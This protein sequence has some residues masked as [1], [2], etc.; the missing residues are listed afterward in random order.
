MP[1]YNRAATISRAIHSILNQTIK[2]W[3]LIVVDDQSTD[4]TSSI[5]KSFMREDS[6]IHY[7]LT[8]RNL[9]PAHARNVGI[10]QAT[11]N[12]IAFLDSDDEWYPI[13]LEECLHVLSTTSYKIV[14]ALWAEEHDEVL[15][16][17]WKL[18]WF[19]S[20]YRLTERKF[21]ISKQDK[22]W[23]FDEHFYEHICLNSFYCFHINTLVIDREVIEQAGYLNETLRSNEDFEFIYRILE[24][25]K[26]ATCNNIHFIYHFGTDNLYAFLN[27]ENVTY[28][29]FLEHPEHAKKHAD[30][31]RMKVKAFIL[32]RNRVKRNKNIKAAPILK[33]FQ[34][35]IFKRCLTIVFLCRDTDKTTAL[36][37]YLLALRYA[38]SLFQVGE[39]LHYKKKENVITY[40]TVG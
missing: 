3:E 35:E 14:S 29:Y 24:R 26:L 38:S 39:V 22:V 5:V 17:L 20:T 40:F 13:H 1:A 30:F 19:A 36:H 11:G 9:G 8:D 32:I 12:Y 2:D 16:E 6:R 18:P 25:Y 23:H 21:H 28:E 37:H 33:R 7:Y 31:L 4:D 15:Y 10:K 27:R 34:L